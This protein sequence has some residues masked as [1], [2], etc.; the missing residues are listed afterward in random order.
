MKCPRCNSYVKYGKMQCKKC[1][2]HFRYSEHAESPCKRSTA[3]ILA[4]VGGMMGLHHFYLGSI[5]KGIIRMALFIAFLGLFVCPQLMCICKTGMFRVEL[6]FIEIAGLVFLVVNI[7]SYVLAII[8]SLRISEG[9]MTTDSRG[10]FL[11]QE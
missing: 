2:L 10:F 3:T 5:V 9:I 4:R 6:D 1:G 8:E 11:R 7:I